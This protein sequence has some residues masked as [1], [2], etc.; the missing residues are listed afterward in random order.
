MLNTLQN[1][2]PEERR[3]RVSTLLN[4]TSYAVGK[5]SGSLLLGLA[6]LVAQ[7]FAGGKFPG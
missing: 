7:R 2:I 5:I 4:N 3:A 1:L 6:P